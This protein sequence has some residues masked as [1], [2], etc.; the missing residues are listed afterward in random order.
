MILAGHEQQ[1]LSTHSRSKL[2]SVKSVWH[3]LPHVKSSA[4]RPVLRWAGSK[5]KLVHVLAAQAP[6]RFDRYIEPFCGSACLFFSLRPTKAVLG[7]RNS[8]LIETYRVLRRHPRLLTRAL[9]A[10]GG[11]AEYYAVRSMSPEALTS[12]E[13]AA[14]FVYLSRFCF[15]GVYRTNRD[16]AFNV[17]RGINTG[18]IPTDTEFY[19][20]SIALRSAELRNCDFDACL[21]DV[22]AG[23]FVYLDPPYGSSTR[24]CYG[25]YGYD[26]F[27]EH[28]LARLIRCLEHI[29][30]VGA[31]FL[32]SF[33]ASD[34][35]ARGVAQFNSVTVA[36]RRHVAGFTQSR[37]VAREVLV[38]NYDNQR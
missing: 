15:N 34:E 5:R 29:D 10:F 17:P 31:W 20:T 8:A 30:S 38:R 28:D 32:L 9:R 18:N 12:I 24:D 22:R 25:E 21:T 14:R 6:V 11:P 19:R 7:D 4:L 13:A 35:L 27:S 16:G 36:V 1:R 37:A 23:D 2:L 33:R 3:T 26:C